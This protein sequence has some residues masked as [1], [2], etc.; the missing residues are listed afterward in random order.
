M[1]RGGDTSG[2]IMS[3]HTAGDLLNFHP[4][5]HS[6]V[7]PGVIT[8]SGEYQELPEIDT[9]LF[10]EKVINAFL[11]K[12]LLSHD[13]ANLNYG[14]YSTRTRGARRR[15]GDLER[16]A[17]QSKDESSQAHLDRDIDKRAV[18][19]SWGGLIKKVYEIDPLQCPKCGRSMKI[20]AFITD[21]EQL[22]R[23]CKNL[24]LPD[25]RAPPEMGKDRKLQVSDLEEFSFWAFAGCR[26]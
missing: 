26:R 24:G 16:L 2:S 7:F 21:P 25:W 1:V 13:D 10:Q 9:E 19:K 23:I 4:H 20:K 11:E 8:P 17:K 3:L 6:L 18:C 15:E 14:Y 12:D 5:V 22:R